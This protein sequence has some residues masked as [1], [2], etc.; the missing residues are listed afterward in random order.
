MLHKTNADGYSKDVNSGLVVNTNN[1][2]YTDY[3][4]ERE[5]IK[6]EREIQNDIAWLRR[7]CAELRE[8][9]KKFCEK[10]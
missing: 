10:Q 2:D 8:L 5:R 9:F 3:V 6:K 7:E 4:R 1:R